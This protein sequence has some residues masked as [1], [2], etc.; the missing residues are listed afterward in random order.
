MPLSKNC[1]CELDIRS[2]ANVFYPTARPIKR[3]ITI[4]YKITESKPTS[5]ALSNTKPKIAAGIALTLRHD[6]S[7]S[8]L[9]ARV[10][11]YSS[12]PYCLNKSTP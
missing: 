9:L 8:R 3:E 1:R 2:L 5:P 10:S 11:V 6:Q 4:E 12:K 7:P